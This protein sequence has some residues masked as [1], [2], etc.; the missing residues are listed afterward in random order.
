MRNNVNTV[1]KTGNAKVLRGTKPTHINKAKGLHLQAAERAKQTESVKHSLTPARCSS[2][3]R[4]HSIYMTFYDLRDVVV[5]LAKNHQP[6]THGMS[7]IC[8]PDLVP[9]GPAAPTWCQ[10]KVEAKKRK[11]SWIITPIAKIGAAWYPTM[12]QLPNCDWDWWLKVDLTTPKNWQLASNF[13]GFRSSSF[14]HW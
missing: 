5:H 12:S 1:L 14:P 2:S 10:S 6:P 7:Y 13:F 8:A 4:I 9:F 11:V 3:S